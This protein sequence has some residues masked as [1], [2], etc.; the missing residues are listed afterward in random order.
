VAPDVAA[1]FAVADVSVITIDIGDAGEGAVRVAAVPVLD[2]HVITVFAGI[3]DAVTAVDGRAGA[4]PANPLVSADG[5]IRLILGLFAGVGIE[6]AASA[7]GARVAVV[8][9]DIRGAGEG[10]IRFAARPFSVERAFVTFFAGRLIDNAIAASTGRTDA[11]GT[12]PSFTHGRT[13]RPIFGYGA[14]SALPEHTALLAVTDIAVI[15]VAI[16]VTRFQRTRCIERCIRGNYIGETFC[17][18]GS[19]WVAADQPG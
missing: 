6:V 11:L 19:A 12:E 18:T 4:A 1:L 9:V 15:A 3:H 16:D 10:A 17:V 5:A 7:H 14:T 8:T 2:V 13:G